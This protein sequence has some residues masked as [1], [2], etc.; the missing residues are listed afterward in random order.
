[1]PGCEVRHFL[2]CYIRM[3]AEVI[4]IMYSWER[5]GFDSPTPHKHQKVNDMVKVTENWASTLR[6]MN[7]GEIV[8][9]PIS[10]ISS[11]NTTISRLRL[12]MCMEGADWKRVGEI[13][14]KKG[15]FKVK[16]VS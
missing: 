13:D 5:K 15:E 4:Q 10:S 11:V 9:F 6:G 2:R 14:R 3:V 12:E 1:M 7:V 8:I 16:R